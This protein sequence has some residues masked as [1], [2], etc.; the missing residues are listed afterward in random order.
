[1]ILLR[2]TQRVLEEKQYV[3][4]S[5]PANALVDRS[6]FAN[7]GTFSN[8]TWV[9]LPSGLQ[10]M[11]FNGADSYVEIPD[12]PSMRMA[13]G[14]TIKAWVFARS[15]GE[16]SAGQII[17]K[18]TGYAG[19]NGY[20][21]YWQTPGNINT[22]INA[23]AETRTQTMTSPYSTWKHI[24]VVF[25]VSG[26]KIYVNGVDSTFAGGAETALPPDVAGVVRIGNYA[27]ATDRTFDGYIGGVEMLSKVW[28]Q[29]D[30]TRSFTAERG[31]YGV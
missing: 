3:Q 22:Q 15:A 19:Q 2:N 4:T 27:G 12:S 5:A 13:S 7:N 17:S 21:I 23:G 31:L 26:R 10:V 29:A 1:M 9:Q 16:S 11:D 24:A 30:V 25:S 18:G 28:T 14:G 20:H 6:R 8:V